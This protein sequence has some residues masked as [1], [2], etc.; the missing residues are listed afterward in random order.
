MGSDDTLPQPHPVISLEEGVALRSQNVTLTAAGRG[1]HR[2]YLPYAFTDDVAGG[3]RAPEPDWVLRGRISPSPT[4]GWR[5][6]QLSRYIAQM[7]SP[8]RTP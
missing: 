1:G 3:R 7:N 2:K 4:A 6:A 8:P 5:P